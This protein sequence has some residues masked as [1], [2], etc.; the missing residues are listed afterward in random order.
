M[1]D[2]P[3]DV[4]FRHVPGTAAAAA[5]ASSPCLGASLPPLVRLPTPVQWSFWLDN[6]PQ[7]VGWWLLIS[8]LLLVLVSCPTGSHQPSL[9]SPLLQPSSSSSSS[10]GIASLPAP[11]LATPS[12]PPSPFTAAFWLEAHVG[13]QQLMRNR[14]SAPPGGFACRGCPGIDAAKLRC[15]QQRGYVGWGA[16]LGTTLEG[17]LKALLHAVRLGPL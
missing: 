6:T 15:L 5:T 16:F 11:L 10:S 2:A 4:V 17:G 12:S 1:D 9:P 13:L 3:A 7:L 8:S 14:Y